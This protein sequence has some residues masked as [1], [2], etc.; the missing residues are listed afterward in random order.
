ML[1]N[2]RTTRKISAYYREMALWPRLA[3][4][5]GLGFTILFA[6]FAFLSLRI[7]AESNER[8]LRERLVVAEMAGQEIDRLLGRA[9]YELEKARDFAAF[10][11]RASDLSAEEHVLSHT[12]GRIGTYSLGVYFLDE[13]ANVVLAAPAGPRS[14]GIDFA[15][16][17]DVLKALRMGERGVSRPF[18]EPNTER[19]AI[20]VL[21]PIEDATGR[22][23]SLL[24]GFVDVEA[25]SFKGVIEQASKLET[26]GHGEVVTEDGIVVVTT[27]MKHYLGRGE[28]LEFY[29]RMAKERRVG[30]E[31]VPENARDGE[32]D[33][34]KPPMH[35]MA[36]APLQTVPWAV[37]LGGDENETF[38]PVTRLR[39]SILFFGAFALGVVLV[40]TLIGTRRL[41][42][43]VNALTESAQ[44]I[45]SGDLE[46]P[47]IRFDGGEIGVLAQALEEMRVKLRDS[48]EEITRWGTEMEQ[49]VRVRTAELERLVEQVSKLE[50]VREMERLR[51]EF[52]SSVSHE[53]KTPLGFIKG[54]V[55]T[56]LRTDVLP[57]EAT[58]R[59]FLEVIRHEAGKLQEL[60]DNL[61]DT[62][63]LQ[64]GGLMVNTKPVDLG[65][66]VRSVVEKARETSPMHRFA[67]EFPDVFPLVLGDERRLEQVLNNLIDN[68]VKYMPD[69]GTI[70]VRGEVQDRRIAVGVQDEG[71]GIP[72]E[73]L[74]KVFEPFFRVDVP[75]TRQVRGTGLGLAICRGIVEAHG[76]SIW[77]E[78]G[79]GRGSTF[80]FKLPLSPVAEMSEAG[81]P[82]KE[83]YHI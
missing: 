20:A 73:Y 5:V 32:A 7:V 18:V 14:T 43:P 82:G 39:D 65:A 49:R 56:L 70:R 12:Y 3:L 40:A 25:A 75:L 62:A 76:G 66:L 26:T 77:V 47:V 67:L 63:R 17:P 57:S 79:P 45:S 6:I 2:N 55:T 1:G 80:T 46:S 10:D 27:E 58:R 64:A 42:K 61:L 35:V 68:A 8:I 81:A 59:E 51:S 29:Q 69:G 44:R 72:G 83:M 28:H 54:Y 24:S 52:V 60:V 37:A 36:Y 74:G 15:S 33:L 48:L 16:N 19:T 22:T 11:P 23:V 41:V 34:D 31:T 13:S 78:S 53:L 50:G 4:A 21:V 71:E 38:A 9:F 30:V